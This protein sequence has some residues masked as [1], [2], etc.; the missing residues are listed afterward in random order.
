[1]SDGSNFG[2]QRSIQYVSHLQ[3]Q[4]AGKDVGW[5]SFLWEAIVVLVPLSS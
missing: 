3:V 4:G 1:M 5:V 2:S